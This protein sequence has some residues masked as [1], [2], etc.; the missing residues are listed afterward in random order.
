MQHPDEGTIHAWLDGALDA[1]ESARV[2]RHAAECAACAAAVAEARGLV[3]GSSR[4]LAALD[5]VPGGVVPRSTTGAAGGSSSATR[6]ARPLWRVLRFTPARAAAAAV[7]VLAAG[8][9]LVLRHRPNAA[10]FATESE[11]GPEVLQAP[12]PELP[13]ASRPAAVASPAPTPTRAKEAHREASVSTS[14]AP[15]LATRKAATPAATDVAATPVAEPPVGAVDSA[16]LRSKVAVVVDSVAP[17]VEVADQARRVAPLTAQTTGAQQKA[18]ASGAAAPQPSPPVALRRQELTAE[19]ASATRFA[20]CYAVVADTSAGFPSRV[21]LDT[22]RVERRDL[23]ERVA[24]AD[25]AG[26]ARYLVR[27]SPPALAGQNAIANAYWQP[28]GANGLV[29]LYLGGRATGPIVLRAISQTT[30][31]GS[32]I[33][34]T[35]SMAVSLVRLSECGAR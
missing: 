22:T 6:Q 33:V 34:G 13:R 26:A 15:K 17:R 29:R 28:L 24:T 19:P 9:A 31:A 12:R 8:S 4:I 16:A 23:A 2:E 14:A 11:A 20:G 27:S 32:I 7:I 21:T 18:A 30:L 35:R 5:D 3:A 25:V 10:N 1:D